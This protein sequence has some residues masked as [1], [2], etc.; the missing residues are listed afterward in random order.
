[1]HRAAIC[2]CQVV[3]FAKYPRVSQAASRL[4]YPPADPTVGL[5]GRLVT[6]RHETG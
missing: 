2:Y 3:A 1:M 6:Y 4:W 5:L